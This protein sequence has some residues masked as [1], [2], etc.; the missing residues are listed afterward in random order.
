MRVL[1]GHAV[2]GRAHNAIHFTGEV[3]PP[4]QTQVSLETFTV[5]SHSDLVVSPSGVMTLAVS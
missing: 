4:Q 3:T 1:Y 2:H 5:V